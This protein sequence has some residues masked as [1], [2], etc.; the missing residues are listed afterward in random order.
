MAL[1]VSC[2]SCHKT[3]RLSE[4]SQGKKMRCPACQLVFKAPELPQNK[5]DP[6]PPPDEP[7]NG[8]ANDEQEPEPERR[9]DEI[10][11][12]KR[13]VRVESEDRPSRRSR[14]DDDHR[15][16]R[17]SRDDDYED[18]DRRSRR[19][20]DYDRPSR[21]VRDDYD[22]YDDRPRRRRGYYDDDYGRYS[23]D[24]GNAP[25]VLGILSIVFCLPICYFLGL[26]GFVLGLIAVIMAGSELSSLPPGER[27]SPRGK[28]LQLGR[29]LG[30]VGMCL[31]VGLFLLLCLGQVFFN[32]A[33]MGRF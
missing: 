2:P 23:Q 5:E 30:I 15:P 11:P 8:V 21:R 9:E 4:E 19:D 16:S 24:G 1:T 17:R 31:S 22:D 12:W 14:D 13:P 7:A 32:A 3:L 25:K 18:D 33:Q 28:N 10:P 6:D 26:V 20:D 27:N 29:T